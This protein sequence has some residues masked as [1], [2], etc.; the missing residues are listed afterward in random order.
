MTINELKRGNE[1]GFTLLEMLLVFILIAGSGFVL[2]VKLPVNLEKEH[3]TFAATQLLE[4]IRETRQ[5]AL[6]ENNWYTIKF[7]YQTGDQHYQIFRQGTRVK[8]V[9]FKDGIQFFGSPKDLTFNALGRSVG[10]TIVLTNSKGERRS[11]IV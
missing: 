5:A 8:D 3:L 7:Y 6:A 10:S 11:I 9:Y 2:L 4:D 1:L